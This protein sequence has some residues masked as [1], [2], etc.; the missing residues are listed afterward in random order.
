MDLAESFSGCLDVLRTNASRMRVIS[1]ND[2]SAA[3][4]LQALWRLRQQNLTKFHPNTYCDDLHVED[5]DILR[6]CYGL[7]GGRTSYLA[8]VASAPDMLEEAERMVETE[9]AWLL[10]KSVAPCRSS[11]LINASGSA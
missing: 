11:F 3:E 8:R 6:R 1:I 9:K 7:V 4:S 10:S 2:L 5:T